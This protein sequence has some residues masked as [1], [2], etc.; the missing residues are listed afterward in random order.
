MGLDIIVCVKQVSDPDYFS[1]ITLDPETGNIQRDKVPA[2]MNS[3]DEHALEEALQLKDEFGG[4]VTVLSMGPPA[5]REVL[6]WSLALGADEAA[7]LSDKSF[8]GADSWATAVGLAEY[9]KNKDFDL[10]FCGNQSDDGAT[11]QVGPQIAEILEIPH[12]TFASSLENI[13]IDTK[14][15][16]VK[17]DIEYGGYMKFKLRLPGLIAVLKNINEV[18]AITAE[19][20]MSAGEK[21]FNTY[22]A[23]DLNIEAE[24]IG[25]EGSPTRVINT[26]Q[27]TFEREKDICEGV[28]QEIIEKVKEKISNQD[29]L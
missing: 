1:E 11:A 29:V 13:D 19:G 4:K 23:E 22:S 28:S 18:R 3:F 26:Y 16:V 17:R 20:M 21:E 24:N 8:A 2:V 14:E 12:L 5:A 27:Q 25:L 7:L 9:I 15:V 6:E 10:I